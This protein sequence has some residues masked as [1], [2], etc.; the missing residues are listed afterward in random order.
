MADSNKN[1]HRGQIKI[2]WL[3]AGALGIATVVLPP[4]LARCGPAAPSAA[5]TTQ[6]TTAAQVAGTTTNPTTT[7]TAEPTTAEATTATAAAEPARTL[8]VPWPDCYSFVDLDV[9][10]LS[11]SSGDAEL[12]YENCGFSG[13]LSSSS[14]SAGYGPDAPGTAEDCAEAATTQAFNRIDPAD[15]KVGLTLCVVT[16]HGAVAWLKLKQKS[17]KQDTPDLVFDLVRWP[18][19]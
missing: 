2:F 14:G 5:P 10:G 9:P 16:D 8:R 11:E 13:S 1:D 4:V 19:P 15:L 12:N 6:T 3:T 17:G 7:T 18:A